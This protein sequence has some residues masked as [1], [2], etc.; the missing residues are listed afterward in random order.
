MAAESEA[1]KEPEEEQEQGVWLVAR[2]DTGAW[3]HRKAD[4][5]ALHVFEKANNDKD[6]IKLAVVGLGR[7]S[8]LL[9]QNKREEFEIKTLATFVNVQ[10]NKI[11][12]APDI[13]Y[14]AEPSHEAAE[15]AV[16]AERP[17]E[18]AAT[19]SVSHNEEAVSSVAPTERMVPLDWWSAA[20]AM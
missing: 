18:P 14:V 20:A 13:I 1:E 3:A 11:V 2:P 9:P 5:E 16:S 15:T 19:T 10:R 4:F 7:I 6:K 8:S 17:R 12:A